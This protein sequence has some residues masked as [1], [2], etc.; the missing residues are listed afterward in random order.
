MRYLLD[1]NVWIEVLKGKNLR[2]IGR[3]ANT[4]A[5]ELVTCSPVRAELM[6][7]AEKYKDAAS[8]KIDVA[9]ALS[10]AV[11]LPFDDPCAERYGSIRHDLEVRRCVIGPL[12]LQ[13]AAIAL[14]HDLILVTGN[15]DEFSRVHGLKVESWGE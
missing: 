11:S 8:R 13:I 4:P 9:R 12:D 10:R 1:T 14:A 7:G 5:T 6:H 2:L 15:V 3:F